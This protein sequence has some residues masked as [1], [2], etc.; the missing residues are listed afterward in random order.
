M[1]KTRVVFVGLLAIGLNLV[2]G[3]A[4]ADL[5]CGGFRLHAASDGWTR[6]NG[7]KVTSQKI[8]FLEQKDDWDNV[9]TDMAIMPAKDG[10]MYG[11]EFIK[12]GE[13][14]FLNV[15]LLQ[16]NR[17]APRLIGSFDC[18]RVSD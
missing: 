2:S 12:R 10:F 15:E 1:K 9:K 3:S 11:F 17:D 5:Q 7:E 18:K 4:F 14:S 16:A 6:I 13:K 8:T